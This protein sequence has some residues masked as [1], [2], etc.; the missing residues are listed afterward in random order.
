VAT[1]EPTTRPASS[2]HAPKN[3]GHHPSSKHHD[4]FGSIAAGTARMAGSRWA[5]LAALGT[6]V[7]WGATG[8]FFGFSEL[9]QLVINTGTTIVTFLMVFLIQNAQNRESKAVHLK[10]DE[11]IR[12]VKTAKNEIIDI[13]SLTEEELDRLAQRYHQIAARPHRRLERELD[14][15]RGEVGQVQERVEAVK[16]EVRQVEREADRTAATPSAPGTGPGR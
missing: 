12:A 5:F 15:I 6:V 4:A 8:P 7:I 2:P 14:G 9:W 11:L 1:A 3:A 16:G 10:L 13:E